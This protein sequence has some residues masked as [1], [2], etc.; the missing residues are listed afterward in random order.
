MSLLPDPAEEAEDKEEGEEEER[1]AGEAAAEEED[2]AAA[3]AMVTFSCTVIEL[4]LI[5]SPSQPKHASPE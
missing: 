4:K 2:C 1:G 3:L 5:L